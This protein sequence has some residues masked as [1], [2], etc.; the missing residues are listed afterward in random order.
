MTPNHR[1]PDQNELALGDAWEAVA[2][3]E[4]SADPEAMA[5]VR[6]VLEEVA[7]LEQPPPLSSAQRA[8]IWQEVV[9]AAAIPTP[10]ASPPVTLPVSSATSLNGHRPGMTLPVAPLP[11]RASRLSTSRSMTILLT[12]GL[13]AILL[14]ALGGLQSGML[15][16]AAPAS[17]SVMAT[18]TPVFIPAVSSTL[19]TLQIRTTETLLDTQVRALPGGRL[20]VG[21][22]RW[23]LQP[24][25][26]AVTLPAREGI[27]VLAVERG[28]IIVTVSGT[29]HHLVDGEALEVT[30]AEFAV[31]AS[32]PAAASVYL[33]SA[34]PEFSADV[35]HGADQIWVSGD[36]L[37]H[38]HEVVLSSTA[39]AFSPG[40]AHLVLERVRVPPG[41]AFPE[42]TASP[43]VWTRIG[44][45][46]LGL[47]LHGESLPEGWD[48]GVEHEFPPH[49]QNLLPVIAPGTTMV[50]RNAGDNPL[51][52]Y[53]LTLEPSGKGELSS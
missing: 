14:V 44:A 42:E 13:A 21:V 9:T 45:G 5:V 47:S 41:S 17:R 30:N 2:R 18:T 16:I 3:G 11:T 20:R 15:R 34:G 46:T 37:V 6:E 35:G 25:P 27:V 51:V 40:S 32:G 43:W 28:Q 52:L 50:M 23:T 19:A 1:L 22:D 12:L 7:A 39:E 33:V 26:S 38:T 29:E 48:A 31:H 4:P 49:F 53:R 24:S 10:P 36:P 8:R